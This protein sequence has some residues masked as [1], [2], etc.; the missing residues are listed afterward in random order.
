MPNQD[1]AGPITTQI[2][3]RFDLHLLPV[4]QKMDESTLITWAASPRHHRIMLDVGREW[5]WHE[6]AVN[7]PVGQ[8]EQAREGLRNFFAPSLTDGETIRAMLNIWD[9][10][11][12][13]Q[14]KKALGAWTPTPTNTEAELA[15]QI[16]IDRMQG[17][18]Q[19]LLP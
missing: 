10:K 12:H 16:F 1:L 5:V 17:E 15:I 13:I 11:V 14:L 9:Q 19:R 6:I 3:E 7:I 18:A 4:L 8:R 2:N